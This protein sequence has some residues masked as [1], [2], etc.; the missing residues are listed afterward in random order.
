VPIRRL[1]IANRGEIALRIVRAA[2]A[3]GIESV[4]AASAADKDSLAAREADRTVVLGPAKAS[5][6]YLDP[7][8]IVHAAKA[9]GC[10]ALHPGYGFLSERTALV[11]L[12]EDHGIAFV[13]P[14]AVSMDQVGGKIAAREL[15]Q[16][17]G[18]PLVP[19]SGA[20]ANADAA[21]AFAETIGFPVVTKASAGGG[22]RGMVVARNAAELKE[23]FERASHEAKEA[24]GDGTL[25]LERFVQTARHI[26]VQVM[27]DGQGKVLHFGERDCSAQR[28][29]QKMVE[30]AP[31][32]ILPEDV[33]T[34][35]HE[36]AVRLL[37]SIRYR[38]AGTVEFLYDVE[39]REFYFIEVNA[40][41]QVEH[42][43]S[44]QICGVDLIQMQLRVAGGGPL[45]LEQ[46]DIVRRGHAIEVRVI[47]EDPDRG[48][49]PSPGRITHWQAPSGD[50]VRLDTAMHEG[51]MVPPFYDSMIAKLIVTG[52]D[53]AQA[54]Q[55]LQSAL[56]VF[57]VEGI[58]TN[59][60]LLRHIA[61][62]PDYVGNRIS[63]RW[64]E[65]TLL[66]SYASTRN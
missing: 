16:G 19:G 1:L 9:T 29:Y 49:A 45:A 52:A 32:A 31:G 4:L 13:G 63:T 26:E 64:L 57:A 21:L 50:G 33:R 47:A 27:G 25:F 41:I 22:G 58:A 11:T 42:P 5:L 24:F 65:Q 18:V 2:R 53:R 28:R 34:R 23:G 60:K 10:D 17:A 56:A 36:S 3:L 40:R 8:L 37:S 48:F 20:L 62:H 39:R 6:S 7:R 61:A 66:P 44:E 30:E 38:N 35:L 59:I 51:A 15:A 54:V 46:N 43:V 14:T 12:C 55:R